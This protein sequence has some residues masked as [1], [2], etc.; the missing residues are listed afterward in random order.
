M[1]C[2]RITSASPSTDTG[3][4]AGSQQ[5][6]QHGPCVSKI[7]HTPCKRHRGKG[8]RA[9]VSVARANSRVHKTALYQLIVSTCVH[10]A[11]RDFLYD[12]HAGLS[13]YLWRDPEYSV[14]DRATEEEHFGIFDVVDMSPPPPRPAIVC[15]LL[16]T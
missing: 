13:T 7:P 12:V 3:P 1:G 16:C 14:R 11:G 2:A 10:V 15:C 8:I 5:K 9:A 4:T 6:K